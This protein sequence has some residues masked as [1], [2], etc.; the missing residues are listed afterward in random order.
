VMADTSAFLTSHR[1]VKGALTQKDGSPLTVGAVKERIRKTIAAL[2]GTMPEGLIFSSGRDGAIPH[3]S[4]TDTDVIRAGVPI[5]FDFYPQEAGGGYFYDMTRTWCVGFAPDE[6][7][8]AHQQV[9]AAYQEAAAMAKAGAACRLLQ[10]RVCERF[11]AQGHPTVWHT[12]QTESG[13]VHSLGHGVGLDIHEQPTLSDSAGNQDE[14]APGMVFTIEPGLYYPD[15]GY[16][17]RLE[18]TF[19]M[20]A[21]G[22]AHVCA[23]YPMDLVLPMKGRKASRPAAKKQPAVKATRMAKNKRA[24]K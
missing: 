8:Q 20:D 15:R 21:K 2:G 5:V 11:E 23:P 12:P 13:Y 10:R 17:I 16:G 14:L 3:S 22:N 6:V 1:M 9:L 18:D 19:W 4:G 24:K 7:E